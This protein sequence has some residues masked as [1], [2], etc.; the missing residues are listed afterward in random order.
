MYYKSFNVNGTINQTELDGGLVSTVEEPKKLK[1]IIINSS[2]HEGN[3]I[4][5][6]IGTNRVLTIY[7]YNCD[8]Q[9]LT[10]ADTFPISTTKLTR[11]PVDIL[12]PK[13]QSF[14]IGIN[15]G[16]TACNIFGAY[17]YEIAL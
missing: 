5:G 9:E 4:E 11:L 8:T 3:I 7:D 14:K 13:G 15:C 10:G 1:E 12:I 2:A 6:W 17:A 16:G